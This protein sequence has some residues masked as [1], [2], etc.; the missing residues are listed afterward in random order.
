ME[1]K[2]LEQKIMNHIEIRKYLYTYVLVVSGG[3][4]SLFFGEFSYMKVVFFIAGFFL[5]IALVNGISTQS[6]LI[7]DLILKLREDN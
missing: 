1:S 3:I 6:D 7:E 4:L 5:D 2:Y